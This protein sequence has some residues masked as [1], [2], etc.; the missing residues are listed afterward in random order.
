MHHAARFVQ[1]KRP[2]GAALPAV[3]AVI[4]SADAHRR[5]KAVI[6]VWKEFMVAL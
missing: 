6:L 1:A 5:R 2:G 3:A 4:V